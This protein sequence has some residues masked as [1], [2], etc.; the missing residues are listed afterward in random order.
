MTTERVDSPA[1]ARIK[2]ERE[3]LLARRINGAVKARVEIPRRAPGAVVPLSSQQQRLWFLDQLVPGSAFANIDVALRLDFPVDADVLQRALDE[4]VRRHESLRTT[5]R[6]VDGSAEQVVA[7]HLHVPLV[8]VPLSGSPA[9]V[10]AAVT[11]TV[12]QEARRP[13]DLATGPLVRATLLREGEGRGAAR[14]VLVLT[15]HH[16]VADGWSIR[17]FFSELATLYTAFAAGRRSPLPELTLQYPDYAVWQR[18]QLDGASLDRSLTAWRARLDG[19]P[20]LE[21]PTDRPRPALQTFT[22]ATLTFTLPA[23]SVDRLRDL[24]GD[25]GATP[26]MGLLTVFAALLARWTGQD[27]LVVGSYVAGRTRVELEPLIGFFVNTLPLR[28]RLDGDPTFRDALRTVREVT[29]DALDHQEVPFEKLVEVLAPPRDLSRNPLCQVAFQLVTAPAGTT[30]GLAA[31]TVEAERG[32][33]SFDM[34]WS[35]TLRDDTADGIG[36]QGTLEY[37][38]ALFDRE[39]MERLVERFTVLLDGATTTPDAPLSRIDL[40]TDAEHAMV[41]AWNAT[42]AD[43]P[44]D[45]LAALFAR[46]VTATPGATAVVAADG[47]RWTYTDLDQ[48]ARLVA[49]RL[50]AAGVGHGTV[51]GVLLDRS[52]ELVATAVALQLLGATYLPLDPASPADRRALMVETARAALVVGGPGTDVDVL[53]DAGGEVT[54]WAAA[55]AAPADVGYV[56][57]TSGSTG[58]PKGVAGT[59][60]QV[61]NRLHWMWRTYPFGP[62]EVAALRTPTGFVDSLW[63]IWG[64]LLQ[65]VP[66]VVVGPDVQADTDRLVDVLERHRVTRLWLVPS[67]LRT[68]LTTHPELAD[69]LPHL[70][71]WVV[72]GEPLAAELAD[73]FHAA[74]PGRELHNCYG[75]SEVWDAT[76]RVCRAG[77]PVVPLG[78]PIANVRCHVLDRHGAPTGVGVP[79]ELCVGGAGLAAGYLGDDALTAARFVTHAG[80]RV[81]RTGDRARWLP[82]GEL[83]FLGRLDDQLKVRGVRLEPGDVEAALADLPGVLDVAVAAGDGGLIAY[84]VTGDGPRPTLLDV[85]RHLAQRVPEPAIPTRVTFLD[86]LPHTS[87]GKLDRRALPAPDA[88]AGTGV[89]PRTP[90]ERLV[91]AVWVDVLD[92]PDAGVDDNF[93]EL[94]G[95][96]LLATQIVSRLRQLLDVDLPLHRFFEAPTAASLAAV[97]VE[98][99]DPVRVSRV[100]ELAVGLLSMTDDEVA[101]ALREDAS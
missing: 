55:A 95:H 37:D 87:S 47:T 24:V 14:S 62:D 53:T 28:V 11:R 51:V 20:V 60:R 71:M 61:L 57:F 89:Q 10:Q 44:E 32:T 25:T 88:A 50:A 34:V 76:W 39:T 54:P 56:L 85:R 101:A 67:F 52:P 40:T 96:S 36:A 63:E 66:T 13:F 100:A 70:R 75:T 98:E 86:A 91:L 77:E 82:T 45:G 90:V 27:D 99:G 9:E 26:F 78:R 84:L 29:L 6:P 4:V 8:V 7:E 38:T 97:I 58:R 94:G 12:T 18:A 42:D 22:G 43:V 49:G 21:P 15:V 17:T 41:A 81:Y 48:R 31:R 69:R 33:A 73:R 72:S 92:A 5:I 83:E 59:H 65:G 3:A 80:E 79:G 68:L 46:Q 30:S 19:A 93:F 16:I 35:A 74:M 2:A 23:A 1:A 64:A